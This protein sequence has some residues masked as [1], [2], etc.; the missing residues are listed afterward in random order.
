MSFT[1]LG[2]REELLK[3]IGELGFEKPMPIQQKAIPSLL[4]GE[5]DFIGLAQTGTGKTG[6]YGLA[7]LQRLDLSNPKPQAAVIC[8]T[9]ELCLQITDDLRGFARHLPRV[10]VVP[11][12]SGPCAGCGSTA[13]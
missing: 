8:P 6:A 13:A 10:T 9:R 5:R 11:I 1:T 12:P 3:A 4:E 7:M 2:L